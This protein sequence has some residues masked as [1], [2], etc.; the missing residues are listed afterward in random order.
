MDDNDLRKKNRGIYQVTGICPICTRTKPL[1]IEHDHATD[2]IR[3]RVCHGCNCNLAWFERNEANLALYLANP[4]GM[5]EGCLTISAWRYYR[6]KERIK[7]LSPTDLE[8]HRISEKE[9]ARKN[10]QK[11]EAK[12]KAHIRAKE[13]RIIAYM[14]G[15]STDRETARQIREK[16]LREMFQAGVPLQETIAFIGVTRSMIL[17]NAA[18]L[19]FRYQPKTGIPL[20]RPFAALADLATDEIK[21][22]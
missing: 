3:G 20:N 4:P 16:A 14:M 22:G 6:H 9:R 21:K 12:R 13:R 18:T 15:S 2:L 11:P 1:E 5:I 17:R 8:T 7:G 19:G 10:R